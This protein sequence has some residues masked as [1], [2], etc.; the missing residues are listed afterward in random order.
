MSALSANI[1]PSLDLLATIVQR[2]DFNAADIERLR[3]QT[4]TG[5][6][7]SQKDPNAMAARALPGLL[8]GAGHPYASTGIGDVAAVEG[9]TRDDLVGFQQHYLRPDNMKIFVVSSLPLAELMP[10]LEQRFGTWAPPATA[11]GVKNFG[12]L[13][14]RPTAQK[15]VLIDRPGSPQS[16]ILGGQLTP[17]DPRSNIVPVSGASEAL[18]G[19]FL[20]RINTDI[21]ETKGWSYGVRSSIAATAFSCRAC[22]RACTAFR[23]RRR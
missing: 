20:S 6:A 4:L 22:G 5:I 2:P 21:R 7:Q 19:N 18:G 17:I 8:Y 16:V 13:P 14:A 12:S 23:W 9:F 11:K 10:K 1:D 3:V 15:I